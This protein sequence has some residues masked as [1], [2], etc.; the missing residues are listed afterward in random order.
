MMNLGEKVTIRAKNPLWKQRFSY[1]FLVEEYVSYSGTVVSNPKWVPEGDICLSTGNPSFPFRV[2]EKT[3]I[4]ALKGVLEAIDTPD[5]SVYTIEGDKRSYTVTNSRAI[6]S[7]DCTGFGYRRS[8]SH[9]VTAKSLYSKGIF[10][11][12][13]KSLKNKEEK[14]SKKNEN[15][16]CF[17]SKTGVQYKSKLIEGENTARSFKM[18]KVK[19]SN[20]EVWGSKKSKILATIAANEGKSEAEICK[21]IA[22]A[23]GYSLSR[24]KNSYRHYS[25]PENSKTSTVKTKVVKTKEVSAKK[26]LKEV[27]L[28]ATD[29]LI[30]KSSDEI[31]KIKEA[32]LARLREVSAKTRKV[33]RRDYGDRVAKRDT[34]EGVV[35][36]DPQLA[37]EEVNSILRDERLIEVCPKF[38]REDA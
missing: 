30:E 1:A 14:K 28:K 10:S 12:S 32:N 11:G 7:C 38:I 15:N 33:V 17:I 27:G 6:W 31:D 4:E 25:K 37:R 13:A 8:C 26:L 5:S 20:T 19:M 18:E 16:P 23:L 21:A 34:S 24:A 9:V 2:I 22:E 29:K 3:S 36:F 35:D